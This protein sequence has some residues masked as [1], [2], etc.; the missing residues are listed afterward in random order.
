M[1]NGR[2]PDLSRVVSIDDILENREGMVNG[3]NESS[4]SSELRPSIAP[5]LLANWTAT[6]FHCSTTT[7]I[8]IE[9]NRFITLALPILTFGDP[10]LPWRRRTFLALRDPSFRDVT[11]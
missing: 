2:L 4:H 11:I 9:V 7:G 5:K 8:Q 3:C 10:L 1:T 6:G